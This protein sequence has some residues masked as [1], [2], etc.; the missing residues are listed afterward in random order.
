MERE[1]GRL[2]RK[3]NAVNCRGVRQD[4]F[5][6]AEVDAERDGTASLLRSIPAELNESLSIRLRNLQSPEATLEE[7]KARGF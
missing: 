4:R 3:L 7:C 2:R 5:D 1:I 6:V